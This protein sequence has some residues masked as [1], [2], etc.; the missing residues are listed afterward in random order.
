MEMFESD[1][2]KNELLRKSASHRQQMEGEIKLLTE[3]TEKIVTNTL[4]IGGSL[5]LTYLLIRQFSGAKKKR[6]VKARKVKVI[7]AQQPEEVEVHTES[8]FQPG[9]IT[10]IGTALASQATLFLLNLA[11]EKLTEYLQSLSEKK[12]QDERA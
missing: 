12:A 2:M 5:A 1:E 3:E 8:A 7:N 9:I 6:K 11:K 10:Q 4:I